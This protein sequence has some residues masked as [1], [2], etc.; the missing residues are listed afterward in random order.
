MTE[1]ATTIDCAECGGTAHLISQLPTDEPLE[2]GFPIAY[3]CADCTERFD[4]IWED[5][6]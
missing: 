4:Y 1:P 2:D 6:D 5:D 3:R